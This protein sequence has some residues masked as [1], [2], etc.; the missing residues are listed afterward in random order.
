MTR[1][2]L[3][4]T[5]ALAL[6]LAGCSPEP[7][8]E[9]PPETDEEK[10]L[11]LTSFTLAS[12]MKRDL[13]PSDESADFFLR[14]VRDALAGKESL[15]DRTFPAQRVLEGLS[16]PNQ[17]ARRNTM[18]EDA[19]REAPLAAAYVEKAAAEP[20]AV[21]TETGVVYRELAAG[22]GAHPESSSKVRVHYHGTLRDGTVSRAAYGTDK[23]SERHR[24][25]YEL[26]NRFRAQLEE[27]GLVMAGVNEELD[28]VEIVEV[29]DH[30]WFVGAQFHPEFKTKPMTAH[31]LFR[32]FVG[33]AVRRRAER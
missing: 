22:T 1:W 33:A 15:V 10:A 18:V 31:P 9:R 3:V 21:T 25:R 27:A 8:S 28:L 26:N 29:P 13:E 11:Y 23:I 5:I 32:E 4:L 19:K 14:G 6:V 30:P 24:H 17:E 7:A 2:S 12:L 16:R 20:G